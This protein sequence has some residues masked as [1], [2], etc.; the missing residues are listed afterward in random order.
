LAGSEKRAATENVKNESARASEGAAINLSLLTLGK[1]INML[2]SNE[3]VV[4]GTF[5]ESKLTRL[6]QDSLGGNAFLMLMTC[7]SPAKINQEMTR[8]TAQFSQR[9]R[10]MK[11]VV[12]VNYSKSIQEYEEELKER[13]RQ[14]VK[15]SKLCKNMEDYQRDLVNELNDAE[16]LL[17]H[18]TGVGDGVDGSNDDGDLDGQKNRSGVRK[19]QLLK[20]ENLEKDINEVKRRASVFRDSKEVKE[21]E[22]I[23]KLAEERVALALANADAELEEEKL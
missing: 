18:I 21:C 13:D 2:A 15:L 6:L 22:N 23:R 4:S 11:N 7:M 14:M 5:R 19:S 10:G 9:C 20:T 16:K 1:V 3:K 8:S 12:T 17:E